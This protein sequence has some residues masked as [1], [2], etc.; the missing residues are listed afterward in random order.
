MEMPVISETGSSGFT[1]LELMVVLA[2][3][4]L[5]AGAWPLAAPHAFPT[6]RLRN[7]AQHLLGMV[8]AA[9]TTARLTGK[10]QVVEIGSAGT[11]YRSASDVREMPMGMTLHMKGATGDNTSAL[12]LYP[13]GSSTGG[14]LE[15]GLSDHITTLRIGLL[16]G[17]AEIG[18]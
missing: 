9:R 12:W 10:P 15:L 5:L 2:I 11:V 3:L 1:L 17:R 13:D 8:R 6:Q 7:E 16:T 18:E 4:A 14:A